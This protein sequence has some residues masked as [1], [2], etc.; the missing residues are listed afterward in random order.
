MAK[1]NAGTTDV[2][3]ANRL[4]ILQYL[5]D[6]RTHTRI[7]VARA[8][9]MSPATVNRLSRLM[10]ELGLIEEVGAEDVKSGRP[11]QLIRF[12]PAA[13]KVVAATVPAPAARIS[14]AEVNL[15]G[16]LD[17]RLDLPVG[18]SWEQDLVDAIAAKIEDR[19]GAHPFWAI[20]VALPSQTEDSIRRELAERLTRRFSIPAF[21]EKDCCAHALAEYYLGGLD[22]LTSM[23]LVDMDD[24]HTGCGII[25]DGE[26]WRGLGNAAGDLG[27]IRGKDNRSMVGL[28]AERIASMARSREPLDADALAALAEDWAAVVGNLCAV[29]APECLTLTGLP[30]RWS[31]LFVPALRHALQ[32]RLGWAPMV[33]IA[34]LGPDGQLA[35]V[36]LSAM[37]SRGGVGSLF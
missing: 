25:I 31:A 27:Q 16:H 35:G 36:G 23:V 17:A 14:L 32:T 5:R 13:M 29:L 26:I 37:R 30:T 7:E 28:A 22:Q 10:L 9:K 19:D 4:R 1:L 20:G 8:M 34:A 11:G 18:D 6:G 3:R 15:D 2:S 33:R 12:N 21:V 24:A